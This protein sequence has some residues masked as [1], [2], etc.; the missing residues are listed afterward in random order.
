MTG[1]RRSRLGKSVA[2]VTMAAL[3]MVGFASASV[4]AAEP[5]VGFWAITTKD[6]A[7]NI[8][9]H[10]FSGWTSDGLE[11]DQDV[12][13]VLI[14]NSCYGKWIKLGKRQYG[15]THPFFNFNDPNFNGEG[16]EETEG[17]WDGTSAVIGY[18]IIVAKDGKTFTGKENFKVL[19]GPDPYDPAATV[20]FSQTGLTVSAVRI[21]VDKSQLP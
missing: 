7:G 13:P 10:I 19:S 12:A 16:T 6:G 1:S 20:L 11:F 15:L 14:E 18:T 8:I 9:D 17:Q 21:E 2:M 5:I 3:L 4:S